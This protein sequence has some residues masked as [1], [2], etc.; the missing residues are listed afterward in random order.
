M[1]KSIQKT[2]LC[3]L[4][5]DEKILL[6]E[7]QNTWYENEK[8]L[9]PG[10]NV[11]LNED[12]KK[13]AVRELFEETGITVAENDLELIWNYQNVLNNKDWDNYYYLVR[14]CTG[15][16]INK[17]PNRHSDVAWFPLNDLPKNTSEVVYDTL[18]KI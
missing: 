11:D 17:E 2:T 9:S 4:I 12:P 5:K 3:F 7:R 13:A 16:L 14:T 15:T 18:K 8:Y 1:E 10:G 6:L